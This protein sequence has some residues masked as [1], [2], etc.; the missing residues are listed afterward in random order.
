MSDHVLTLDGAFSSS[1]EQLSGFIS[2]LHANVGKLNKEIKM[3]T[4]HVSMCVEVLESLHPRLSSLMP[5]RPHQSPA[6]AFA[7][8]RAAGLPLLLPKLCSPLGPQQT[9]VGRSSV[10][11]MH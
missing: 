9:N 7:W 11:R 3:L 10:K 5:N 8:L 1:V 4:P 6:Q 2:F